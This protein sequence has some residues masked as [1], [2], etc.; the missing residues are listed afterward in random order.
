MSQSPLL[1]IVGAMTLAACAVGIVETATAVA[2]IE[3]ISQELPP[4]VTGVYPDRLIRSRDGLFYGCT[5]SGGDYNIGT[6]FRMTPEGEVTQ[7]SSFGGGN[8][9]RPSQ[10]HL[11]EGADGNFYGA[12]YSSGPGGPFAP[13]PNGAIVRITREGVSSFF[14]DFTGSGAAGPASLMAASDGNLYGVTVDGNTTRGGGVFRVTPAG[15]VRLLGRLPANYVSGHLVEAA[16]GNLYGSFLSPSTPGPDYIFKVTPAGEISV[17]HT[18]D[19]ASEG[20]RPSPIVTAPDG[21]LYG[22]TNAGGPSN[23][24]TFYK[25][26]LSGTLT[27]LNQSDKFGGLVLASDGNFFAFGSG[28]PRDPHSPSEISLLYRVTREGAVTLLHTLNRGPFS[29]SAVSAG[30]AADLYGAYFQPNDEGRIFRL[31]ASGELATIYT[32]SSPSKDYPTSA[33]VEAPDGNLYGTTREGGER[34][35]GTV[36]RVTLSGERDVMTSFAGLE[37]ASPAAPLTLG[38]DGQLYGTTSAGGSFGNGTVFRMALNGQRETLANFT[39][40]NGKAASAP[41]LLGR[42]GAFY[43]TAY[44]G[45]S[46]DRGTVF[47]VSPAGDLQTLGSFTGEN[48]AFPTSG[49]IEAANGS[50]YGMSNGSSFGALSPATIFEAEAAGEVLTAHRFAGATPTTTRLS[51]LVETSRGIYGIAPPLPGERDLTI[52][53]FT[54]GGAFTEI[55]RIDERELRVPTP[56]LTLAS[57]GNFYSALPFDRR[58]RGY[59]GRIVRLTEDGIMSTVATLDSEQGTPNTKLTQASDGAFYGTTVLGFERAFGGA[60]YRVRL[61]APRVVSISPAGAAPGEEITITGTGFVGATRLTIG[62]V[63]T[64]FTIESDTK[65]TATVPAGGSG[66]GVS[67]STP[68]GITTFPAGAVPPARALN[69][70][71]RAMVGAGDDAMIGGMIISGGGPKRVMVRALGPSLAAA[72]VD[73]SLA[74]PT[75]QVYNA[76]GAIVA[77][78]D[79]WSESEDAGAIAATTI[80]P[81]NPRESAVVANLPAGD[82]TAVVRGV[83]DTSGIALVE[84]YD[85]APAAGQLANIATRAR[86]ESDEQVMIGGFILAG[87]APSRVMLRAI[88]PSLGVGGS[89]VAGA[90]RDPVLELRDAAGNLMATNDD[91]QGGAQSEQIAATGIAPSDPAEAAIIATLEPGSYTAIVHGSEGSSGVALVEVYNLN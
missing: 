61:L 14:A 81:P 24:G 70:S 28:Q 87:D 86:V 71:T 66:N 3:V 63:A 67:I 74:D 15:E 33:L 43:G 9:P 42:D 29:L 58:Q 48:G 25:L 39:F 17:F 72:G 60:I 79:D 73:G 80:A 68:T 2:K 45:G 76:S 21:H 1:K 44:L 82:Y 13:R 23:T 35:V 12:I 51:E 50:F 6:F 55:G 10:T 89:A 30:A 32:F 7:L 53:R 36:F 41:L 31:T 47:R 4:Q 84:V 91:W 88:G 27:V 59:G 65:I 57:D 5:S 78:N 77:A 69:L 18:F 56:G 49:L 26:S 11:V 75:L 85:L 38:L 54:P 8:G 20:F 16:D 64:N 46:A 52:F 90:L 40:Q 37:G 19:P 62:G 34:G 83:A 22:T